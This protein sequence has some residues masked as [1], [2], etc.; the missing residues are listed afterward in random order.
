[1]EEGNERDDDAVASD[2]G[3]RV[4]GLLDNW[5]GKVDSK[6]SIT[7]ALESATFA[8]VV[9]QT[10]AGREFADLCGT[11]QLL[12]QVSLALLLASIMLS[13][14]V[15]MP[16][17]NRRQSKREW[18]SN[19]IYFGHL[20]HWAPDDLAKRLGDTETHPD[21]LARQL[22]A[23]SKIAWRKHLWLQTSLALLVAGVTLLIMVAILS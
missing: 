13:L 17:L 23:M 16:Q 22:V 4:H 11:G 20:R 12:F 1:V 8:F 2:F 10:R 15:V 21:Q 14:L 3:W 9:T 6:A 18:R 7:L 19:T 5:T